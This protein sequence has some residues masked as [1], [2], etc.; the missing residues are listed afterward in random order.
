MRF[1]SMRKKY[2]R[3]EFGRI[4]HDSWQQWLREDTTSRGLSSEQPHGTTERKDCRVWS[5]AVAHRIA[6]TAEIRSA[7]G[8]TVTQLTYKSVISKITSSQIPCSYI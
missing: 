6:S 2:C 8:I 7:V 3:Q 1:L 5:M 4:V